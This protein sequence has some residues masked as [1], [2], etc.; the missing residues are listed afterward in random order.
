MQLIQ[1]ICKDST[2]ISEEKAELAFVP[3]PRKL[4]RLFLLE[5]IIFP[6]PKAESALG[7]ILGKPSRLFLLTRFF[8]FS[9][10][11]SFESLLDLVF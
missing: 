1:R 9:F 3:N 2:I 6:E 8:N 11:L 5:K 10:V 7:S 4:T